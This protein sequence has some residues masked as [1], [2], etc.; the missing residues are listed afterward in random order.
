MAALVFISYSR[1]D[2][3]HIRPIVNLLRTAIAGVPSASGNPWELVF[4]DTDSLMPG[5][6]WEE[7]INKAI[8]AAERMF[9]FWC[10]HAAA[11]D[12]V[13]REYE[14]AFDQ[15]KTVIPVLVDDTPLAERL[16]AIHG[17]DLR[18]LR[19]HGPQFRQIAPVPGSRSMEEVVVSEFANVLD[20]SPRIMLSNLDNDDSP[21][22]W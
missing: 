19:I 7:Q 16:S 18:E 21:G 20:V 4:L 9:V 5:T 14:L 11:S 6:E 13:R 2:E 22:F 15:A 8:T 12:E 17:V 10:Q 1:D 3:S